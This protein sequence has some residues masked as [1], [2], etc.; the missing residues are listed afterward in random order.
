MSMKYFVSG[1]SV[2][3]SMPTVTSGNGGRRGAAAFA[4]ATRGHWRTDTIG[5]GPLDDRGTDRVAMSGAGAAEGSFLP[6][7]FA[8]TGKSVSLQHDS[9]LSRALGRGEK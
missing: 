1:E 6:S 7:S 3:S 2:S 8:E 5:S 9:C 4:E